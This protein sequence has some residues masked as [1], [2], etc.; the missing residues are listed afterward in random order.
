[1]KK[2]LL[3]FLILLFAGCTTTKYIPVKS[4]SHDTIYSH[5]SDTVLK[6]KYKFQ[7]D[8]VIIRDSIVNRTDASGTVVGTDTWHWRERISQAMDSTN[9]Y[10]AIADSL[11]SVK[12]DSVQVPYPVEKT[13]AKMSKFQKTFFW[14]GIVCS[15]LILLSFIYWIH[16]KI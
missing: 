14:I 15:V 10:R 3:I 9:Y 7:K 12:R 16:K 6:F 8:T 2:L 4:V 1:M 5:K 13:V 11:L